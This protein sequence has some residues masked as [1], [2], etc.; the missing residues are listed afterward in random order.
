MNLKAQAAFEEIKLK[1]SQAPVLTLPYFNKVLEVECNASG[2]EFLLKKGVI[3]PSLV[4]NFVM[5]EGST[6]LMTKSLCHH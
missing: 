5:Q 6:P 2:V 3:W 1:L 4:R